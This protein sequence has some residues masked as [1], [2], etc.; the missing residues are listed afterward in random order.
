MTVKQRPDTSAMNNLRWFL[1]VTKN[2][3]TWLQSQAV[4][5]YTYTHIYMLCVW[6]LKY[7]ECCFYVLPSPVKLSRQKKGWSFLSSYPEVP[8]YWNLLRLDTNFSLLWCFCLFVAFLKL[9]F[10]VSSS[11]KITGMCWCKHFGWVRCFFLI[12]PTVLCIS[13]R[14]KDE[15]D[16]KDREEK[17]GKKANIAFSKVASPTETSTEFQSNIQWTNSLLSVK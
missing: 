10:P 6:M 17:G 3:Q 13:H 15:K 9:Y 5:T 7:T 12:L 8:C 2:S 4:F 14:G 11:T 16:G 1:I